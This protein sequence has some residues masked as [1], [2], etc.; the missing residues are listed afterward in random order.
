MSTT[1]HRPRTILPRFLSG[2]SRGCRMR[3]NGFTLIE[4]VMVLVLIGILAVFAASKMG[5]VSLI[6]AS[7]FI[8]KLQADVRYAQNLAM[9]RGKRTRINFTSLSYAVSQDSSAAGDCSAFGAA[10]DPA[11][12][13]GLTITLNTGKFAGITITPSMACLEFDSLGKPYSCGAGTCSAVLSGMT[14]T[15]IANGATTVGAVTVS[16]QTG[17]VN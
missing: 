2:V 8:D 15:V 5:N 17:A 6:K 7:A 9:T 14:I 16:A 10:I 12:S 4:L 11:T 3:R 1:R 13:A